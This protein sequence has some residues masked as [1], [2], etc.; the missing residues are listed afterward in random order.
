MT[1]TALRRDIKNAIDRLPPE[2]LSSLA[3]FVA[4]LDR[5]PLTTRIADAEKAIK[6][7]K[8]MNWRKVRDDV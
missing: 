7:G 1:T 5:P 4:F 3:D 8:G 6:A 2:R